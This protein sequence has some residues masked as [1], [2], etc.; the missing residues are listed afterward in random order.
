MPARIKGERIMVRGLRL[1]I[2]IAVAIAVFFGLSMMR[3]ESRYTSAISN[4]KAKVDAGD[5]NGAF[6]AYG[7]AIRIKPDQPEGYFLRAAAMLKL[8][9]F[10]KSQMDLNEVIRMRPNFGEAYRLRAVC[11]RAQGLADKAAEDE[12]TA[13]RLGAPK[14]IE[15]PERVVV[16]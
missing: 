10:S 11:C 8:D 16:P 13:D 3:G 4:G 14:S 5:V 12:A 6:L 15:D 2:G 9:S 1:L 7:D